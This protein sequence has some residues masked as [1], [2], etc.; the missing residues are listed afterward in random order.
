MIKIQPQVSKCR[1]AV[2]ERG[3]NLRSCGLLDVVECVPDAER[4]ETFATDRIGASMPEGP[5]S[6]AARQHLLDVQRRYQL[7][8]D[9]VP[10]APKS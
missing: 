2:P 3:P 10:S 7:D 4:A 6:D 8:L 5:S 1:N 9:Q